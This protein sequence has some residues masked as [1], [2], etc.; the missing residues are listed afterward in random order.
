MQTQIK[1]KIKQRVL[2]W[3]RIF[4]EGRTDINES[5]SWT[6][7]LRAL[8]LT[9]E[10]WLALTA[11]AAEEAGIFSAQEE[12]YLASLPYFPFTLHSLALMSADNVFGNSLAITRITEDDEICCLRYPKVDE[13]QDMVPVIEATILTKDLVELDTDVYFYVNNNAPCNKQIVINYAAAAPE[14]FME[15][16]AGKFLG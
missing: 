5:N 1:D 2:A 3:K 4:T 9:P 12:A 10:S 8:R 16:E 11:K 15:E 14:E 6:E 7:I 13:A